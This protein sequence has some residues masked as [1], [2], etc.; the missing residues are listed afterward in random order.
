M[1]VAVARGEVAAPSRETFG[2]FFQRW[3]VARRPY[4]EPGTHSD[5]RMHGVKRMGS[6][7]DVRL[8]KLD[9]ATIREWLAA[10]VEEERYATKT[11]NNTLTVLTVCLNH[12]VRDG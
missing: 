6:L 9:T 8:T 10:L 12:A 4:L 7:G 5:Y 2:E 3:L 1:I 11:I